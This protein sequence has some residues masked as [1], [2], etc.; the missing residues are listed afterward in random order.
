MIRSRPDAVL[1]SAVA[2]GQLV[3]VAATAWSESGLRYAG[4]AGTCGSTAMRP[5]TVV[6]VASMTKVVTAAAVMQ[7][8]ESHQ[9]DLDQPAGDFVPYLAEVQVLVGLGDDGTAV[10]RPPITPVTTRQLLAHTSGFGYNWTDASLARHVPSLPKA[11]S[12]SQAGYE[13]PLTFD[14]GEQ[15]SYGIGTDWAG[16]VGE[17]VA[18]ERLDAY[19]ANHLLGPLQMVDTTFSAAM[20]DPAR[21]ATM[22][23]RGPEGLTPIP[24]GLPQN[25]EMFMAGG[26]LY[27]TAVDFLRFTRMLLCGGTLDGIRVLRPESVDQ[28]TTNQIGVLDAAGWTSYNAGLSN[29]VE[30]GAATP[31]KWGLGLLIDEGDTANGRATGTVGWAGL[32]N[33]YFWIDLQRRVT[34]VFVTQVLPFYD[35]VA[36]EVYANFERAIYDATR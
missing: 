3:G 18:G 21:V 36:L 27:S 16:R 30:L 34:G 4:G 13:H 20:F 35:P 15:W 23:V 6:W 17:A 9:L 19:F 12:G 11:L 2:A 8:V 14:P 26:G 7:L 24:F 33:T 22:H 25:P 5:D 29:D 32:P 31:A 1:E 10:L 28:M